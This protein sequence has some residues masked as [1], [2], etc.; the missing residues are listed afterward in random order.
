MSCEAGRAIHWKP[1]LSLLQRPQIVISRI[2]LI[3]CRVLYGTTVLL[4][5]AAGAPLAS[6]LLSAASVLLAVG[7]NTWHVALALRRPGRYLAAAAW[8]NRV[9]W[10]ASVAAVLGPHVEGWLAE[11]DPEVGVGQG[12]DRTL[13]I[14][15]V[16][17]GRGVG[18]RDLRF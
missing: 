17:G 6:R 8:Y 5:L 18:P 4:D 7:A 14:P 15:V 9:V 1:S 11:Q 16:C 10:L 13:K 3:T 2:T 12:G